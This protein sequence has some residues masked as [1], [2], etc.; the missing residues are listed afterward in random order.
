MTE[1]ISH[2][3]VAVIPYVSGIYWDKSYAIT[4]KDAGYKV[5]PLCWTLLGGNFFFDMRKKPEPDVSP[6]DTITRE[7]KEEFGVIEESKETLETILGGTSEN[8]ATSDANFKP[9]PIPY[10]A[11]GFMRLFGG[12]VLKVMRP[13]KDY[14]IRVS[15]DYLT[16]TGKPDVN[17]IASVFLAKIDP[18]IF[19][20][21][22]DLSN[23]AKKNGHKLITEGNGL[24]PLK[25]IDMKMVDFG[26]GQDKVV[27]NLFELH[28]ITRN[29]VDVEVLEHGPLACY[30]DYLARYKEQFI[31]RGA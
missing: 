21:F 12:E 30:D 8:I 28:R 14:L 13:E 23:F 29:T 10:W 19:S 22:A 16:V 4:Q 26:W 31:F 7:L 5:H 18:D 1:E 15:K 17:Y 6:L 2:L 20:C 25:Q 24:F 9:N 11:Q 27:D 3:F